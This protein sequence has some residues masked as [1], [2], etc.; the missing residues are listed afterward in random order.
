MAGSGLA[1]WAASVVAL[2]RDGD[3]GCST[4][5]VDRG[6]VEHREP[7]DRLMPAG[8]GTELKKWLAAALVVVGDACPGDRQPR[9]GAADPPKIEAAREVFVRLQKL[10]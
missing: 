5:R 1:L 7:T 6:G 2:I 10:L 3:R 4:A 9:G 8:A